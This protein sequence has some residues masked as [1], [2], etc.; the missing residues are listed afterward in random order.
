MSRPTTRN[1]KNLL[2]WLSARSDNKDP[3]FIQVGVSLLQSKK[4]QALSLG[5][6]SLYLAMC[7]EAKRNDFCEFTEHTATKYGIPRTSLRRNMQELKDHGF[8][9]YDSAKTTRTKNVYH[10]SKEWKTPP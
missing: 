9:K 6:R 7:A 5:A 1:F 3:Y 2:F 8:I 4:Y 10:F